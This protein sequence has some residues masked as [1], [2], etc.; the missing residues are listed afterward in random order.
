MARTRAG[1]KRKK[2]IGIRKTKKASQTSQEERIEDEN[3]EEGTPEKDRE[4]EEVTPGNQDSR[5]NVAREGRVAEKLYPDAQLEGFGDDRDEP[6]ENPVS[7]PGEKGEISE[8]M[9]N[10]SAETEKSTSN[11]QQDSDDEYFAAAQYLA[12]GGPDLGLSTSSKTSTKEMSRIQQEESVPQKPPPAVPYES[13]QGPL[14]SAEK[15][16]PQERELDAAENTAPNSINDQ[17]TTESDQ[18][19]EAPGNLDPAI[20]PKNMSLDSITIESKKI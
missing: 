19:I 8:K 4:I 2:A 14:A 1:E 12:S 15:M 11:E 16:P 9:P 13:S 7:N 6:V 18:D 20:E 10:P 3:E 5:S 17:S